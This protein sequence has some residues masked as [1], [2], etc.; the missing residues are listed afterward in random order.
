M[1][2]I[3]KS[4]MELLVEEQ[5]VVIWPLVLLNKLVLNVNDEQERAKEQIRMPASSL[6]FLS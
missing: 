5:S 3:D 6:L 1:E 2:E 4:V